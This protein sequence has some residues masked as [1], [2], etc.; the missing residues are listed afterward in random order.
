MEL[1]KQY[2]NDEKTTE[3]EGKKQETFLNKKT[4]NLISIRNIQHN[5]GNFSCFIYI[6]LTKKT[7]EIKEIHDDI[8]NIIDISNENK[9]FNFISFL[10]KDEL[11]IH[12]SLSRTFFLKY[13]QID[14]FLSKFKTLFTKTKQQQI[15]IKTISKSFTNDYKNKHF[16]SL[17]IVKSNFIV[18]IIF[19]KRK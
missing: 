19:N 10:D 14:Y 16:L 2:E 8:K 7:K 5:Q 13:H 15:I 11:D 12:I 1:I 6:K 3:N 9:S 18:V 17:L 4:N